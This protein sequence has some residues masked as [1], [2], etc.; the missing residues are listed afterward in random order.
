MWQ[1]SNGEEDLQP[2]LGCGCMTYEG[3]CCWTLNLRMVTLSQCDP[4]PHAG[5]G[6][7]RGTPLLSEMFAATGLG[8]GLVSPLELFLALSVSLGTH[9]LWRLV[10]PRLRPV[11]W[12]PYA[13][14][15]NLIR[16]FPMIERGWQWSLVILNIAWTVIAFGLAVISGM[17]PL[18][19][20]AFL[21][22]LLGALIA[23]FAPARAGIWVGGG[24]VLLGYG[25]LLIA[26]GMKQFQSPLEMIAV[27]GVGILCAGRV[28]ERAQQ[29]PAA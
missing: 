1:R 15:A 7:L 22:P 12:P 9:R 27:M 17:R 24:L 21:S 5:A 2:A 18:P 25:S 4:L 23:T 26:G 20:M 29:R 8:Y 13:G 14:S 6:V 28:W 19:V 11:V 10:L 16:G 3:K